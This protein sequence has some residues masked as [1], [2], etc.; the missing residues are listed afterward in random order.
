ML[1][2]ELAKGLQAKGHDVHIMT[3]SLEYPLP[4]SSVP[5]FTED[6]YEGITVHRLHYGASRWKAYRYLLLHETRRLDL[7]K[8]L[9][10]EL[11]PDIVHFHHL[12]GF[13]PEAIPEIRKMGYPVVFTPTDFW[14]ICP[15]FTLYN[16]YR[17]GVCESPGNPEGCLQCLKAMPGWIAGHALKAAKTPLKRVLWKLDMLNSLENW[18]DDMVHSVNAADRILPST[19]FLAQTLTAYGVDPSAVRVMP[20]GVDIGHLPEAISIPEQFTEKEPLRVGFIGTFSEYKSPRTIIDALNYLGTERVRVHLS[21]YGKVD[22]TNSYYRK[23]LRKAEQYPASVQFEGTF[24]HEHIGRILRMLHV[25]IVP[26]VWYESSPLVLVSA[27]N[28][29]TPVAVSTLG[30]LTEMIGDEEG[31]F[32]FLP[33]NARELSRIISRILDQPAILQSM[34]KNLQGFSRTT[35]DYVGD[36]E[37]EYAKVMRLDPPYP[38]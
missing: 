32:S 23:L 15:R 31:G 6:E 37:E 33:G 34:R 36:I 1:T 22:R 28:A 5:W 14:T 38:S 35:A 13:T 8:G 2:L 18:I 21:I 29:G 27:L 25:L 17:K 30:G 19:R 11:D 7:I 4:H 24:P 10:S 16:E 20:Y 26:S 3:G 9:V 12:V